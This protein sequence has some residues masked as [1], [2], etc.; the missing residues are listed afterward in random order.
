MLIS[1]FYRTRE[2]RAIAYVLFAVL[3]AAERAAP[4]AQLGRAADTPA[5]ERT[6]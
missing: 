6:Q 3:A 5:P 2:R 1:Q 4:A